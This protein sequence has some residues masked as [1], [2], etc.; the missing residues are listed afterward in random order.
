MMMQKHT[1]SQQELNV[2]QENKET[3]LDATSEET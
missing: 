1:K 3:K 2:V